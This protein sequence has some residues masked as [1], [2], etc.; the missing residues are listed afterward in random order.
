MSV[1]VVG[2]STDGVRGNAEK[3]I[4]VASCKISIMQSL[5]FPARARSSPGLRVRHRS[6]WNR[7]RG[8]GRG[9]HEF[10]FYSSRTIP[11]NGGVPRVL[12]TSL[13][14]IPSP[15]AGHTPANSSTR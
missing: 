11:E 13:P 2:G 10:V 9:L 6:L 15:S 3:A 8:P 7:R 5:P 4:N 1:T 14:M 12:S